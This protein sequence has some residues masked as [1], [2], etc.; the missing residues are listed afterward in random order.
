M[1]PVG[2]VKPLTSKGKKIFRGFLYI[3]MGLSVYAEMNQVS[4]AQIMRYGRAAVKIVFNAT[5][6]VVAPLSHQITGQ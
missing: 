5:I 4:P 3:I 2:K 6:E 1:L